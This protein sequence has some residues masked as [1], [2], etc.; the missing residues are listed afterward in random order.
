MHDTAFRRIM[1]SMTTSMISP[2]PGG[3][4]QMFDKYLRSLQPPC[5]NEFKLH[6]DFN[7]SFRTSVK[8]SPKHAR[9]QSCKQTCVAREQNYNYN[10]FHDYD[11][12]LYDDYLYDDYLYDYTT[13]TTRTMTTTIAT[14][15]TTTTT[16]TTK[17][18]RNHSKRRMSKK[19]RFLIEN[20]GFLFMAYVQ[21]VVNSLYLQET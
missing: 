18:A 1:I 15:T 6:A 3:M 12:Y 8:A 4:Y 2:M 21:Y 16:T 17:R 19:T 7:S 9:K 11:D 5:T 14:T 10:D 13:I 20:P